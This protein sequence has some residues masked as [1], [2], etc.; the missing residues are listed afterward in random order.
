MQ[1]KAWGEW[2]VRNRGGG[3]FRLGLDWDLEKRKAEKEG[4]QK[5]ASRV[6]VELD[7]DTKWRQWVSCR[8]VSEPKPRSAERREREK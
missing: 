3:S 4:R 1:A 6:D 5:K 8:I 7:E 2:G